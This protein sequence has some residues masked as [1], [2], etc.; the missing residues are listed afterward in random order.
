MDAIRKRNTATGEDYKRPTPKQ[1]ARQMRVGN[2]S[3]K[4][5]SVFSG[6]KTS[7]ELVYNAAVKKILYEEAE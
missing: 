5:V 4:V 3:Y 6:K 1:T 7:S 2:S